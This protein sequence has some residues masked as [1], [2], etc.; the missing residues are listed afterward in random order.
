MLLL[1]FRALH[2][3]ISETSS[4]RGKTLPLSIG[5]LTWN[6]TESREDIGFIEECFLTKKYETIPGF[7]AAQDDVC[8]DIGG[9]VGA[10]SLA[11]QQTNQTGTIL[12]IEPHPQTYQRLVKNLHS[13]HVTN[14]IPVNSAIGSKSGTSLFYIRPNHSQITYFPTKGST[15]I[16]VP[17][18]TI[19]KIAQEYGLSVIDLCKIDVEG[20]ELECLSGAEETLRHIRKL[21]LEFHDEG[22]KNE[23]IELLK[24]CFRI[25]FVDNNS[26][27][28]LIFAEQIKSC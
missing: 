9:N 12:C 28:G 20:Y 11:W 15:P 25:R 14:V 21:V 6:I 17:I 7:R 24:D 13:N 16:A 4:L 18:T 19:D 8:L 1:I 5:G 27:I 3:P 10:C 23:V 26:P 22:C 2:K